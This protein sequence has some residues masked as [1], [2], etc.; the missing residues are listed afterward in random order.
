MHNLTRLF[1]E[2]E[3]ATPPSSLSELSHRGT[4]T[5]SAPGVANPKLASV[6]DNYT[7]VPDRLIDIYV[8]QDSS[9]QIPIVS[10]PCD[11]IAP[12]GS[13]VV[14]GSK[15]NL[16]AFRKCPLCSAMKPKKLTVKKPGGAKRKQMVLSADDH[17]ESI[18]ENFELTPITENVESQDMQGM[19]W[20]SK[21]GKDAMQDKFSNAD[22]TGWSNDNPPCI[23]T[24]RLRAKKRNQ[25]LEV[26]PDDNAVNNFVTKFR[27]NYEQAFGEKLKAMSIKEADE[28]QFLHLH[29][30]SVIP[31]ALSNGP[32][33]KGAK[34]GH[35]NGLPFWQWVDRIVGELMNL[36]SG[37]K[38]DENGVLRGLL[39]WVPKPIEIPYQRSIADRVTVFIIYARKECN[40][41][42]RE[43][44]RVQHR[45][46]QA[47][48]DKDVKRMNW[49]YLI[50]MESREHVLNSRLIY[51]QEG[52]DATREM[53]WE[54]AGRPE[55]KYKWML[56]KATGEMVNVDISYYSNQRRQPRGGTLRGGLTDEQ[57]IMLLNVIDFYN[58]V[59]DEDRWRA[60]MEQQ[61]MA[62]PQNVR[63]RKVRVLK[64]RVSTRQRNNSNE[65]HRNGK[66]A[67]GE[68]AV[69]VPPAFWERDDF[70]VVA[71]A[72][73]LRASEG[74]DLDPRW[75][76]EAV[77]DVRP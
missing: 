33:G 22:T 35:L 56:D 13:L 70:D 60:A 15:T 16:T 30:L 63:T 44:G 5:L 58:E 65:E 31:R 67:A 57:L 59:D 3:S 11:H 19:K 71:H 2:N 51:T 10:P 14:G 77:E 52:L 36:K 75:E 29:F 42:L 1:T 48:I 66:H 8:S 23:W 12:L 50:G 40:E 20:W 54:F 32:T 43:K 41:E 46:P 55:R 24:I 72:E 9:D 53:L 26:T 69:G 25:M 64:T 62:V 4:A 45:M 28:N 21:R 27:H 17:E 76:L 6:T 74:D 37:F 7:E 38:L 73:W 39:T 68:M 47:W 34:Y 49:F 18:E 61:G